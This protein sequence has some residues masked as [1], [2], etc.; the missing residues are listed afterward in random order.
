[1]GHGQSISRREI[2][3]NA[4]LPQ[5]TTKIANKL[6]LYLNEQ[7]KKQKLEKEQLKPKVSKRN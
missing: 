6:Y 3:S 4:G 1:M 5:E 2:H 7:A